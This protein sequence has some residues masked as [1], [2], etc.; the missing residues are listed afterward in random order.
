MYAITTVVVVIDPSIG[1]NSVSEEPISLCTAVNVILHGQHGSCDVM[2]DIYFLCC[3]SVLIS[4]NT[5]L[6]SNDYFD[7]LMQC[8]LENKL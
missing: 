5:I 6:I 1:Y 7:E 8:G 4:S 2:Q 3:T